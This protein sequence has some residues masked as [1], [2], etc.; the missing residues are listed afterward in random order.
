MGSTISQ[1]FN[2]KIIQYSIFEENEKKEIDLVP[3]IDN[4]YF[5]SS[6]DS[7]KENLKFLKCNKKYH[8]SFIYFM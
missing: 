3:F 4:R 2:F 7:I 6:K 5:S 8:H 1:L